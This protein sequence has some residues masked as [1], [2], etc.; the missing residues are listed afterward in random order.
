MDSPLANVASMFEASTM[1][2]PVGTGKVG[3]LVPKSV[4]EAGSETERKFLSQAFT[5]SP[6]SALSIKALVLA[7]P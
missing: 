1:A 5:N 3:K 4:A 2:G 6:L 7:T